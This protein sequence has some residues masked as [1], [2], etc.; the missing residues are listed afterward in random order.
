MRLPMLR[1]LL[2]VATLA[3]GTMLPNAAQAAPCVGFTDVDDANTFC[4]NVEWLKNR[5][6]TFGCTATQY[7]PSNLVTRIE[8]AAFLR[9]LGDA[10]TPI[11]RTI[12]TNG[13]TVDIDAIPA[14]VICS[15]TDY[16]VAGA[17]RT[18]HGNAVLVTGSGVG[19]TDVAARYVESTNGGMTWTPV[20]PNQ[21]TTAEASNIR[22]TI[23]VLLPPREL[24]VGT[25]YRYA[26]RLSRVAGSATT[27]DPSSFFCSVR[28]TFENRNGTTSPLDQDD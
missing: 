10:L 25:T 27:A 28:L 13:N 18:V 16:A 4:K 20:S 2:C 26:L 8:M 21:A 24:V 6:I 1:S 9:R 3:G 15:T 5:A 19:V 14:P 17:P 22:Q 23:N 12:E 11:H 7:C